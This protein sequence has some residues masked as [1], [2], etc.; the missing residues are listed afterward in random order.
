[1]DT[2]EAY[3]RAKSRVEAKIGFFIH[4]AVFIVVNVLLIIINVSTST[5]YFWF[6]WPLMGWGIGLVFHALG[7][8]VFSGGSIIKERLIEKEMQKQAARPDKH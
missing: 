1:M 4:L 8:F 5:Q 7:V 2:Q 3:Q 6:K